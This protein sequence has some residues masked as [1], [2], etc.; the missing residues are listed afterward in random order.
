MPIIIGESEIQERDL[1]A[2]ALRVFLKALE[3]LGGPRKLIELRNLTW[4]TSLMEASYAVILAEEGLKTEDEIAAFL[5]LTRQTVRNI[6]RADPELVMMK[7]EGELREKTP[8]AHTAGGLAKLAY[9]EIKEGR[10]ALIFFSS[11]VEE[12][13]RL[14]GVGWPA[15]VLARLKGLHFPV[16]G[17]EIGQ[18]LKGLKVKGKD[19]GDIAATK[20]IYH[21]P[22][23][24]LQVLSEALKD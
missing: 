12:G 13:A 8:K 3:L 14:L 19:L 9:R 24:I 6:L 23:E 18:R 22:R 20:D 7:L 2:R 15:E 1:D 17:T 16:A 10:D 5:G 11:L 21:H 4:V